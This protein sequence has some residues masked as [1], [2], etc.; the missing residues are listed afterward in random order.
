MKMPHHILVI[1]SGK[2][3]EHEALQRAIKFA[4]YRDIH[5]HLLSTNYEPALDL[6]EVLPSEQRDQLKEQHLADR[7]FYLQSIAKEVKSQDIECSVIVKWSPHLHEVIEE[8]VK[9]LQP[10]LVI[11][12]VSA[13]PLSINPFALPTDR[14]L[15]RHC[16]APLLLVK[17]S[18]WTNDP[19]LAAV[20]VL[21]TDADH[22][23]LNSAVIAS[24]KLFSH[25]QLSSLH[26]VNAYTT[27]AVSAAMD[28]PTLDV[29]QLNSNTENYHRDKLNQLLEQNQLVPKPS[30]LHV[31]SGLP[32]LAIAKVVGELKPQLVVMGSVGRK[33]I[34]AALMGN[35]AESVL[36]R[37]NC[38]VLCLKP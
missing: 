21:T 16:Q 36:A 33:G 32:D 37:L 18:S 3:K 35:T 27:Y 19:I 2:H 20:D 23:A 24:A 4:E 8:V 30:Q 10:D 15:I 1:I 9:T 17:H 13:E 29:K 25:I 14:H 11:K 34:S 26:V 12:R 5:I 31:E 6:N 7:T 28:F 38:E 22:I